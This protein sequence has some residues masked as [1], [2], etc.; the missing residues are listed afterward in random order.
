MQGDLASWLDAASGTAEE[1]VDRVWRLAVRRPPEPDARDRALAKLR[2]GTLSRAGLLREL[3]SSEEFDRVALLDDAR[4]P[5]A[6]GHAR[7]TAAGRGVRACCTRPRR[8]TSGRSR[9]RGRSPAT[10]ASGVCSMSATPSP[11]PLTSPA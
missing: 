11:S 9:S 2:D 7:A 8:P 4:S 3:V 5:P 10:T 1:F 6:S